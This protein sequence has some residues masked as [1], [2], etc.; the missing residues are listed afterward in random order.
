VRASSV[1]GSGS[2][3][4]GRGALSLVLLGV[5][6][7]GGAPEGEDGRPNLVLVSIDSLRARNLGC[8]G[9]GRDTSPFLDELAREGVRFTNAFSTTSW[10]LPAHAALFTGLFDSAHGL[11]DNGLALGDEHL[12]LAELLGREGYE[13]AG[14]FGGPY[15]HPTF[16]LGQGFDTYVDCSATARESGERV[17]VDARSEHSRSHADVTGPR[18]R[19]AVA[20]WAR[21]RDRGAPCFL[22][23]HLWDVHYDYLAPPEYVE[24]FSP[25]YDGPVDGRD[26]MGEGVRADMP[27]EDLAHLVALYDAEIRFTDDVLRGILDDLRGLGMLDD[28]V[29]VVTADHGEEFFEHGGKGHQRTLFDE[30]LQVPLVVWAPSGPSG[31]EPAVVDDQ[32]RLVDLLPTLLELAGGEGALAV[33]GRSLVPLLEGGSLEPVPALAELLVNDEDLRALRTLEAKRIVDARRSGAQVFDLA[34]DPGEVEPLSAPAESGPLAEELRAVLEASRRFRRFL[35][36]RAVDEV[37]AP[38]DVEALLRDLGYLG[39]EE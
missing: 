2:S 22:F 29:V 39:S 9:Y 7:C 6:A 25:G 27:A 14:F 36:S 10:T 31:I 11:V 33:Q 23:V 16:G 35:G 32:V 20:A 8:Y 17:R 38:E 12:T 21:A 30:V 19:E 5:L 34:A 15:L 3:A 26:V 24:R 4:G 28:A 1:R 13:T 37:D 18:T